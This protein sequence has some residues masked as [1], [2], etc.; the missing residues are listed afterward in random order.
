MSVSTRSEGIERT[1]SYCHVNQMKK[2]FLNIGKFSYK[3]INTIRDQFYS[4]VVDNYKLQIYNFPRL[5]ERVND[6]DQIR[7]YCG[8]TLG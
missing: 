5:G 4:S 8:P 1:R 3:Q 2:K 6:E 7:L